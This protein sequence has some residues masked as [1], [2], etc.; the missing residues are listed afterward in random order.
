MCA[1]RNR[2]GSESDRLVGYGRG[3]AFGEKSQLP[4]MAIDPYRY[5]SA[6][7]PLTSLVSLSPASSVQV[8]EFRDSIPKSIALCLPLYEAA[9]HPPESLLLISPYRRSRSSAT[10]TH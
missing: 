2:D 8:S 7:F 9:S 1:H 10:M 4:L 5:F 6:T 3:L